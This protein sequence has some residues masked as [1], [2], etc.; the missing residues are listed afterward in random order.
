M[1]CPT[2]SGSGYWLGFVED[3]G[4]VFGLD[5]I[6]YAGGGLRVYA[7]GG[8]LVFVS[9]PEGA[10]RVRTRSAAAIDRAAGNLYAAARNLNA[11]ADDIRAAADAS[12]DSRAQRDANAAADVFAS[13]AAHLHASA[14]GLRKL[15]G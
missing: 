9:W 8:R 1:L 5:H 7:H 10:L 14:E 2:G 6:P 15:P 13:A 12:R 4:V 3:Q 11:A